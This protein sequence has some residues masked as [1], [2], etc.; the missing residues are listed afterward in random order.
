MVANLQ[1][2][3]LPRPLQLSISKMPLTSLQAVTQLM[4][5][6]FHRRHHGPVVGG[7]RTLKPREVWAGL[8]RSTIHYQKKEK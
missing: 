3:S 7:T 8:F 2:L 1:D 4:A 5:Q 6:C